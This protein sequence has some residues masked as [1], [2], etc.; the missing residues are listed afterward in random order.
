MAIILGGDD[1][2]SLKLMSAG[3][4]VLGLWYHEQGKRAYLHLPVFHSLGEIHSLYHEMIK[5]IIAKGRAG[6]AFN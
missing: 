4:C 3:K 5:K 1:S 6:M 2:A